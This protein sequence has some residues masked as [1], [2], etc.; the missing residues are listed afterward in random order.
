VFS[1]L[2]EQNKPIAWVTGAGSGIGLAISK[3]LKNNGFE[4]DEITRSD[5]DLSNSFA[6]KEWVENRKQAPYL[7][8]CNAGINLPMKISEENLGT[9]E[10]IINSNYAGHLQLCLLALPL[11]VKNGGG[12]IV[13][14][15]SAYSQRARAGRFA[16]SISK[17]SLDALM[18]SIALEYG[19]S[20]IL[21]NSVS[22]GFIE[23]RLTL[24]NNNEEAIAKILERVPLN[25]L[26]MTSEVAN[27]VRFLGSSENTYITGQVINIDGG[28][29]IS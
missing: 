14:I 25:R 27:L 8:V 12:R 9:Y 15:S 23:T 21:A 5:F 1:K 3:E 10:E 22:P 29:S 6:I 13:F 18:R 11:L 20:G 28:F 19:T 16:Y 7:I 2:S 17:S 24:Q 4:V 26:G